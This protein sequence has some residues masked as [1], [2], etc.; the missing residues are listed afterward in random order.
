MHCFVLFLILEALM[1]VFAAFVVVAA[2]A[3]HTVDTPRI[4]VVVV[5]TFVLRLP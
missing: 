5:D 2:T 1:R 3:L 4:V